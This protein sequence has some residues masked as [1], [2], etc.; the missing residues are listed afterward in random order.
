MK[1][2][3]STTTAVTSTNT[4][5]TSLLNDMIMN[6]IKGWCAGCWTLLI[7]FGFKKGL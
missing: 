3:T 5:Q 6:M 4:Q 1:L 2:S 7:E